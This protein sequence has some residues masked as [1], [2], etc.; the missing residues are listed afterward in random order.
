[1]I[2]NNTTIDKKKIAKNTVALYLRQIISM[3]ISIFTVRV[4]LQELGEVDY[5]IYNVVGGIVLLFTFVSHS[6]AS[7]TQRF[8]SVNIPLGVEKV[9]KVF[10][11]SFWMYV[12]L[13]I[14][15]FVLTESIGVSLLNTIMKI[16]QDRLFA[17]N[18][19]LQS[20]IMSFLITLYCSSYFALVITYEKMGLFAFVAIIESLLKLAVALTFPY[21]GYD[22]LIIY[23]L[24]LLV[25]TILT[26][27]VYIVYCKRKYV[28]EVNVEKVRTFKLTPEVKRMISFAFWNLFRTLATVLKGQG[29]NILLNI[30]FS[31]VVNA[32]RGVAYQIENASNNFVNSIYVA[33]R[34]Q[35]FQAYKK[36][37]YT[38]MFSLVYM[39]SK[40]AFYLLL[41]LSSIMIFQTDF[42]VGKWLKEAP[43]YT[44]DFIK[45]V[46]INCIVDIFV[47]PVLNVIYA[48]GKIGKIQFVTSVIIFANLP[49]SYILLFMN[50]SPISVYVVSIIL[51]FTVLVVIL[52]YATKEVGLNWK[53]YMSEVIWPTFASLVFSQ[54]PMLLV[55]HLFSQSWLGVGL[56]CLLDILWT[57][58]VI[59]IFGL[60]KHERIILSKI[61]YQKLGRK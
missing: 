29:V 8:L 20:T 4:V 28:I 33:I 48:N 57:V 43:I 21:F 15:V 51:S 31:P 5:G 34:P 60:K 22:G 19:V 47:T 50:F 25:V 17:A 2:T 55:E 37:E 35:I 49:I 16:P 30:F 54:T 52:F 45:L 11:D 9:R 53:E 12:I 27:C 42:I 59:I 18:C 56:F 44:T 13:M 36:K 6:L 58:L 46:L 32:A 38:E 26:Q 41:L 39:S 3:F 10:S 7:S 61:I 14:I 1:M 40:F 23:S 24:L